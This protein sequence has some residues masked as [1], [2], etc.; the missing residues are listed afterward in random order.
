[1]TRTLQRHGVRRNLPDVSPSVSPRRRFTGSRLVVALLT[2]ATVVLAAATYRVAGVATGY[3]RSAASLDGTVPEHLVYLRSAL[4]AGAGERM[5]A[6][7]PEGYFFSHVL[8]GLSWTELGARRGVS[9]ATARGQAQWALSRLSTTHGTAP[10]DPSLRPAYGIFYAGWSLL[11][12]SNL[13]ALRAD[14]ASTA[15]HGRIQREADAIAAALTESLDGSGSPFLPA[16]PGGAWPVD[17]VVAVAALLA[18]DAATRTG[19]RPLIRR[20]VTAVPR[21]LDART[22]L[23]PHRVE[24]GTGRSLE[25][26]RGSSQSVI[27][28]FWPAADPGGAAESYRRYRERF[29][30]RELGFVGVREHPAGVSKPGDVDSGPLVLG[31]SLSAS[32]VTIGAALANGDGGLATALAREAEVLGVP[33]SWH[34]KRRYAAGQLPVGDAFLVWSRVTAAAPAPAALPPVRPIWV[35]WLSLPWLVLSSWW[36]ALAAY[37]RLHRSRRRR[38]RRR[39]CA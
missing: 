19:H 29:V 3:H 25:G 2:V 34:G 22:G 26:S 8:Y 1:M 38:S 11:L 36:T 30:T 28:R 20:W 15:D 6:L 32:A 4:E 23:L 31:L 16:Y 24:V 13:A 17:T 10:F 21:Y 9:A 27:Q 33:V 39:Q 12:R 5:Q 14:Q 18:A 7:F 37:G 35:W